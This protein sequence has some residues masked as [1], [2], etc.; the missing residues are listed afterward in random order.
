MLAHRTATVSEEEFLALPETMTKVELLDGEVIMAPAPSLLHQHVLR[1]IVRRL[2]DWAEAQPDPVFVGQ[3]P[4]DIRFAPNRILQP[5]AFVILGEVDLHHRG[6][7]T[8]IPDLCI[9][10]RSP[11]DHGYDRVTKRLLYAEAGVREYWVAHLD[12]AMERWWGEGLADAEQV[13]DTLTTPLLP[14]FT[15]DVRS[16]ARARTRPTPDGS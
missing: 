11:N 1:R 8:R 2:E 6:P 15:L 5:D 13:G 7:L 16:L 10:V 3:N 4:V 12:G 14:G 9:E